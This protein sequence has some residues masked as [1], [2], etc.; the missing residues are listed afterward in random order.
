MPPRPPRVTGS[1]SRPIVLGVVAGV[2]AAGVIASVIWRLAEGSLYVVATPSMCPSLCV[3][4]LL[5]ERPLHGPVHPGTVVSFRPPGTTTIYTHR[6]VRVL[7]GGR[8]VTAGDV[9]GRPDPW[10]VPRGR[11]LGR[12]VGAVAGLG[13][14][15][16]CLPSMAVALGG[17]LAARSALA[18]WI[19]GHADLV[20][21]TL[22]VA[23]P[24]TLLHPFVRTELI[25]VRFLPHGTAVRLVNAGLLPI[26]LQLVRGP[27]AAV[28][29]GH[30]VQLTTAAPQVRLSAAPTARVFRQCVGGC[31]LVAATVLIRAALAS[32][33]NRCPERSP[34]A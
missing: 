26:R 15:W 22:L 6:V 21:A 20:F 16:R 32:R 30:V 14:L 28:A 10:T 3:G 8:L 27:S 13:W 11:V 7:A 25:A 19:R 9:Q 31:A 24:A 2:L 29:P 34:R 18:Q 5:L 4:T 17:Y 12:V 1:A 33:E 23:V